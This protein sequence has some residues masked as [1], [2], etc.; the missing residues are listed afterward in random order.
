MKQYTSIWLVLVVV[1]LGNKHLFADWK[2]QGGL[3]V[4]IGGP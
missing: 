3:V 1:Y 2:L 4:I